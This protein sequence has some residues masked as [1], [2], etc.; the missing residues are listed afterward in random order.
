MPTLFIAC[1]TT[2]GKSSSAARAIA[3][4]PHL[5]AASCSPPSMSSW[6]CELMAIASS[7]DGPSGVRTSSDSAAH[8]S[9]AAR[10][11]EYQ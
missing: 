7:A 8:R 11:P 9:P 2:S 1:A 3:R 10:F 4:I 6:D 5:I